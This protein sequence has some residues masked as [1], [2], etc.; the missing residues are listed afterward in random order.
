VSCFSI[1]ISEKT[2]EDLHEFQNKINKKVKTEWKNEN[3]S[4]VEFLS[5]ILEIYFF[6]Q[7]DEHQFLLLHF[8]S[9]VNCKFATWT[10]HQLQTKYFQ[11]F[12]QKINIVLLY[13]NK[14]IIYNMNVTNRNMT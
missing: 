14:D 11:N 8:Y 12:N 9:L 3:V 10:L 5:I 7:K 4:K 1:I 13:N 2:S 6:D